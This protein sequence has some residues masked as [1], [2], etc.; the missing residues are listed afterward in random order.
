M[1]SRMVLRS[2]VAFALTLLHN[3]MSIV[4]LGYNLIGSPPSVWCI[5]CQHLPISTGSNE[6]GYDLQIVAFLV[7]L[8]LTLHLQSQENSYPNCR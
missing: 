7:P 5:S 4:H 2:K 8:L 3:S 6:G 1:T